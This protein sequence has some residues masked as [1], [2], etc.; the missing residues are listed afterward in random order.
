MQSTSRDGIKGQNFKD[1]AGWDLVHA[2]FVPIKQEARQG[3]FC[4]SA[5]GFCTTN[6]MLTC[7]IDG[8]MGEG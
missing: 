5:A 8:C 2:P 4:L 6:I 1:E 3:R 7:E